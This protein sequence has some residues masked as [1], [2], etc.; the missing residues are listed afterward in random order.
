MSGS[1]SCAVDG[2]PLH[3]YNAGGNRQRFSKY[4]FLS[5]RSLKALQ[6]DS[7][8]DTFSFSPHCDVALRMVDVRAR[9]SC[10]F[11]VT[12]EIIFQDGSFEIYGHRDLMLA[13]GVSTD[14]PETIPL[15]NEPVYPNMIPNDGKSI[16]SVDIKVG[17]TDIPASSPL[18]MYQF[19]STLGPL[20]PEIYIIAEGMSGGFNLERLLEVFFFYLRNIFLNL[21]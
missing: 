6:N 19:A 9:G 20:R 1:P 21:R 16:R 5:P 3:T 10:R 14:T 17:A 13:V 7:V 12:V 11:F 15:P 8:N 4:Q 2:S 18:C